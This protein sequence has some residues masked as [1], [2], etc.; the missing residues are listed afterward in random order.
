MRVKKKNSIFFGFFFSGR[1]FSK[2]RGFFL[3]CTHPNRGFFLLC[4]P[5]MISDL[6]KK[7]PILLGDLQK[8]PQFFQNRVWS[9]RGVVGTLPLGKTME[10]KYKKNVFNDFWNFWVLGAEIMIS[11]TRFWPQKICPNPSEFWGIWTYFLGSKS[12]TKN[13]DFGT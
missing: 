3:L 6:Q 9:L 12:G 13:H 10:M 11:R 2:N 1:H 8:N 5:H 7:P 4:T